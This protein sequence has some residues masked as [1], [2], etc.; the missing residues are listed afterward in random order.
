MA[1]Q[2]GSRLHGRNK[3][4]SGRF[5]LK[6]LRSFDVE[7]ELAR[8]RYPDLKLPTMDDLKREYGISS[9]PLLPEF[10]D[11]LKKDK[12]W[13]GLLDP[14]A[15][16]WARRLRESSPLADQTMDLLTGVNKANVDSKI[17][18]WAKFIAEKSIPQKL[19]SASKIAARLLEFP[20]MNP[21]L[22]LN[23]P[24]DLSLKGGKDA[25]FSSGFAD[26]IFYVGARLYFPLA[27]VPLVSPL[28]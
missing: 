2:I 18:E 22:T 19:G 8:G 20:K 25:W 10:P 17:S 9:E 28:S 5:H 6:S 23:I 11:W 13:S 14:A 16:Y 15:D 21:L 3:R 24:L 27:G 26:L 1:P 12:P 7:R 4:N